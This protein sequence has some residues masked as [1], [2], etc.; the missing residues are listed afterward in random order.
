MAT[1]ETCR[2]C[3]MCHDLHRSVHVGI[4]DVTCWL[5]FGW[6]EDKSI[7]RRKG[8]FSAEVLREMLH[9]RYVPTEC[10]AL[11]IWSRLLALASFE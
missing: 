1:A 6:S 7:N 10:F 3:G 9:I 11:L 5:L 8:S 4:L 2:A